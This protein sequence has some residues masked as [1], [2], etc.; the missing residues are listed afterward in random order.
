[1]ANIKPAIKY[2]SRE[3][4]TIKQDLVQYARRYY[5]EVYRDFNEASFGS[6]MLDTVS[7]VGDILSFYLDYQVNETFLDTAAEFSNVVRLSKQ[8]G[9]KYRGVPSA[10]GV[11]SFYCIV[12]TND[13]GLGPNTD[14]VPILKKGST[15]SSGD[16]T[17]YILDEDVFFND[18]NN[19]IVAA[20][21]SDST[22]LPTSYA[23]KSNGKI[24]AGEATRERIPVGNFT[25]FRK[26]AL[27][28]N[29]LTE[30]IS[31]FDEEGH[32]YHEVDYLSQNVVYKA[33]TNRGTDNETVSAV[34]KP[35][36]VPRR[37]TVERIDG[38][39]YLQFGYGS[40]SELKTNSVA[41]PTSITLK[42]HSREFIDDT[43][44]DP[45][46]LLETDKFGVA[47]ANT[48]LT[49]VYRK[50]ST[51]NS[52][53]KVGSITK[54]GKTNIQFDDPTKVSS[55]IVADIR[56]SVEAYN[57]EKIVGSIT[58]PT[59]A[60]LKR[61]AFDNFAVTLQDFEAIAY[62][63]P[64]K[65]GSLKRVKV[66]QDP[67]SFKR[68][69]NMYVL[70]E[71]SNNR[72]AEANN[73][74][75]EN[76]KM[77]L[78]NY[79]MIH[80]TVDILDGKIVNFGVEFHAVASPEFNKFDVLASAQRVLSQHF[81]QPLYMGESLY[82]TDVYRLLNKKVRG[83]IDVKSVTIVPKYSGV[84]SRTT[85]NFDDQTSADGRYLNVP[86]N[87]CLELKFAAKDI[88]GTIE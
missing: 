14:Y 20:R 30:I 69:L 41:E 12:P 61:R 42:M 88:K 11:C 58:I 70:A 13:V 43:S 7:Y 21:V 45:A 34:M 16:G 73:T 78:G 19:L 25:K 50:N 5:P 86:D 72:L 44:F 62:G 37:F 8:L 31:V 28:S 23:I 81:K 33:V 53:A 3:F 18:P 54:M 55:T 85:Y 56:R 59:T 64:P 4:D 40:D 83:L 67:D 77:W 57:E 27:S 87:V 36:V 75:K 68:N 49:V 63:M 52:N 38:R 51:R 10:T 65:F 1:M 74:L 48:I 29:N 82:I 15:M 26:V 66:S 9:Y 79:K 6:L 2:T 76:L 24:V 80:D 60:E 39:Y 35:Y 17:S 47:P 46:K 84:Y 71:D 22:G 32:E